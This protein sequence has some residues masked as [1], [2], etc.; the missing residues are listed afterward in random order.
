LASIETGAVRPAHPPRSYHYYDLVLAGFVA[1]L[2]CSNLIG[3]GKVCEIPL[4]FALPLVGASLV[5][6]AGNIFFPISY[7][8]D[9]VLT[10]VYGYARARRVIWAGFVAMLFATLMSVVVI[11]RGILEPGPTGPVRAETSMFA[12]RSTYCATSPVSRTPPTWM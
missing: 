6:G 12:P 10:E 8:F 4:P 1:V 3:P 9:D 11:L 7:I 2:L 5:F